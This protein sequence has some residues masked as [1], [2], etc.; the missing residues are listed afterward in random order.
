M[1]T[2]PESPGEEPLEAT[3]AAESGGPSLCAALPTVA[4]ALEVLDG[5]HTP[6]QVY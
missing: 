4:V 3:S 5:T 6:E 1:K 2:R